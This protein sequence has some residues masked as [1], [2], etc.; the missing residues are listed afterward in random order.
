MGI[1]RSVRKIVLL[2]G[3]V[4]LIILSIKVAQWLRLGR[5]YDIFSIETGASLL[6]MTCFP[7]TFYMFDL[8]Q[9]EWGSYQRNFIRRM[10]M[11]VLV[12]SPLLGIL[13]YA[14]PQFMFGRGVF[15]ICLVSVLVFCLAW[16]WLFCV[17]VVGRKG[18]ANRLL[19]VGTNNSCLR[20]DDFLQQ[21]ME[22]YGV[23]GRVTVKEEKEDMPCR[24]PLLGRVD[25]LVRIARETG[26][27]MVVID[28]MVRRQR[29]LVG[30]MLK[31]RFSGIAVMTVSDFVEAA[32][33]KIPAREIEVDWLLFVRGFHNCIYEHMVK[34]KRIGD[35]VISG[36]LIL[37]LWPL[38][39]LV[40]I[41]V[42]IDS[43][44]SMLYRQK[45]VG[46]HGHVFEMLKFRSM[47][48]DGEKDGPV[49]ARE[50]DDRITRVGQWIRRCRLDEL[51]QL[52]NVLKGDMSLVG[53]RPER[54]EFTAIL[55]KELPCYSL[56]HVV[57]P[58]ITGWAQIRY[59]YGASV[60]D[61]LRKLEYDLYYVKNLSPFLDLKICLKTV[62]V[63]CM[64]DGAR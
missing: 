31:S 16:R 61:S 19:F 63:V 15:L 58:G 17:V 25:D 10:V 26:V 21:K 27:R 4:F 48:E 30:I 42:K 11:A 20:L 36:L 54:P 18:E 39:L 35:C 62:G 51:P 55:E 32:A 37:L 43:P 64:G 6:A 47:R 60:E 57:R 56:R 40:G 5:Y 14:L 46:L 44:G 8:Y 41:A 13:F 2:L 49:W 22:R 34:L 23:V 1:R 52:F 9:V 33:L 45:R 3:D 29:A 50:N 7:V 12:A 59:H 24:L 53:P 38:M 28:N